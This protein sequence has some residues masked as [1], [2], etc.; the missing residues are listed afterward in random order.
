ME[1][2]RYIEAP[3][4][5]RVR[6]AR[7]LGIAESTMSSA[8]SFMRSGELSEEARRRVLASG[9]A[10][11]MSYLPERE[12]IHDCDGYLRQIFENSYLLCVHKQSGEYKVYADGDEERKPLMRGTISSM[13]EFDR[14][15]QIVAGL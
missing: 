9:E 12:T 15:Q 7:E 1:R 2:G 8:L 11:I 4:A 6:I 3:K 14:V 5:L 10:V 13:D